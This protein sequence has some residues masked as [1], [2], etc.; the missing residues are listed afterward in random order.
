MRVFLVLL[1][2]TLVTG[3]VTA[4]D[5]SGPPDGKGATGVHAVAKAT[6]PDASTESPM[7]PLKW[8]IGT[9]EDSGE[10]GTISSTFQW[11]NNHKFVKR[12]FA[13]RV[14]GRVIL[15]GTQI[16]GWDPIAKRFRSWTFDS[17][18]G[19]GEAYWIHDGD[20]WLAKKKFVLASGA[21]AS[22]VNI[23]KRIDDNTIEFQ[24]TS[25]EIDGEIQPNI[26][27]TRIVR[28]P[29]QHQPSQSNTKGGER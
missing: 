5:Q 10:D 23:L 24:S 21:R 14:D 16:I 22:A 25:R 26:P 7:A 3:A 8:L 12:T 9:W 4:A 2:V 19:F 6:A 15:G 27:P 18:G 29:V 11:A 20:R 28:R 17:E 1:S 13:L